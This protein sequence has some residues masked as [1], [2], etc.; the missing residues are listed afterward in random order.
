MKDFLGYDDLTARLNKLN[1][2][3]AKVFSIGMSER[4]LDIWCAQVGNGNTKIVVTSAIHAR[5]NVT[6]LLTLMQAEYL[7]SQE[8][9]CTIYFVPMLNPDG[10]MLIE[11]GTVGEQKLT[12]RLVEING[13]SNDFSLWKA[14]ANAVD[15]NVNFDAR[16]GKGSQNVFHPSSQNYVGEMAFSESETCALRDFTLHIQPHSTLSYHAKGRVLYWYFHQQ[17]SIKRRDKKIARK[18]NRFLEYDL[19]KDYTDSAGGYKDWCIEK[20]KIPAFTIE[21]GKDEYSH[22]LSLSVANEEWS[23]NKDIPLVL[24]KL[25]QKEKI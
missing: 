6:A 16:F 10:A 20:L 24:A 9:D 17:D 18:L 5:E 15:L 8:I 23:R 21:I 14:N 7:L 11:K 13:G 25:L 2:E 19:G 4:G 12:Q 1:R 22:P 3:G